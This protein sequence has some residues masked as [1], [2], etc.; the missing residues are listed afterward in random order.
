M[1]FKLVLKRVNNF[2][3]LKKRLAER[4]D[5]LRNNCRNQ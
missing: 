5:Q 4:T 2:N 3:E 1:N